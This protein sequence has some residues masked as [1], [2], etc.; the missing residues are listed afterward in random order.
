MLNFKSLIAVA[1]I[2]TLATMSIAN[3]GQRDGRKTG[4]QPKMFASE[5]VRSSHAEFQVTVPQNSYQS[6]RGLSAPAGRS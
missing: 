1:A 4:Q 5:K 3:A 2:T 6:T